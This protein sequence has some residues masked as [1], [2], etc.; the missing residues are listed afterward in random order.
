[1]SLDVPAELEQLSLQTLGQARRPHA[2]RQFGVRFHRVGAIVVVA[3]TPAVAGSAQLGG[4]E[5]ARHL[6]AVVGSVGI[7]HRRQTDGADR[8]RHVV[9]VVG[10]EEQ[11]IAPLGDGG[12]A[13][14]ALAVGAGDHCHR[15]A[16]AALRGMDDLTG[17][18]AGEPD[19]DEVVAP[20]APCSHLVQRPAVRPDVAVRALGL[21]S[22]LGEPLAHALHARL[23]ADDV[24]VGLV[25]GEREVEQMVGLLVAVRADEVGRHVVRRPERRAQVERTA[26]GQRGHLLERHVWAPEHDGLADGVDPPPPGTAGQLRV[27]TGRQRLVV[28][29]GE[30]RELLDDDGARGHVDADGQCLGGEHHLRQ[31]LDEACL[32]GLLER[33]NHPGVVGGDAGLELGQELLVAEHLQVILVESLEARLSTMARMRACSSPVVSR[34]P[35]ARHERAASSHWWRLKMNTIAGRNSRWAKRSTISRR[36]GVKSTRR[37]RLE[38]AAGCVPRGAPQMR[39]GGRPPG[40]GARPTNVGRK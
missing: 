36:L 17:T 12:Q 37:P 38:R 2:H 34:T 19:G 28:I 33:R 16:I 40:W 8:A 7:E 20:S 25:L 30:L 18:E 15:P 9:E 22:C 29:A 24:A 35:A 4:A 3:P 5:R 23:E 11:Q 13:H 32:D 1:M 27:L 21:L 39:R 26:G 14:P 10:G 31:P 6:A